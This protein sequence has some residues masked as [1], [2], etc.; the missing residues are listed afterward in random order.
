[1]SE[2]YAPVSGEVIEVNA[3]LTDSPETLNQDPYGDGWIV[4]ITIAN[5]DEISGLLS[6]ADYRKYVEDEAN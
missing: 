1:M 2:L 3:A 5:P 6:A 4:K